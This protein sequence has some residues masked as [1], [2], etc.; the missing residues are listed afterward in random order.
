MILFLKVATLKKGLFLWCDKRCDRISMSW[1]KSWTEKC[2]YYFEVNV[3]KSDVQTHLI[4]TVINDIL[5]GNGDSITKPQTDADFFPNFWV[6]HSKYLI[7][8]RKSNLWN[9]HSKWR[10][11]RDYV[12]QLSYYY[13]H[14]YIYICICIC[15]YVFCTCTSRMLEV[16]LHD[17]PPWHCTQLNEHTLC[18]YS[19]I[20]KVWSYRI[21]H[22]TSWTLVR[23]WTILTDRP[24]LVGK[25]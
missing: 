17:T 1:R 14:I 9:T 18:P 4:L 15:I 3:C 10:E 20:C 24:P 22:K 23:K 12:W 25:F 7:T 21:I 13:Q 8:Y 5:F 2:G 11:M 16:V 19:F 6:W